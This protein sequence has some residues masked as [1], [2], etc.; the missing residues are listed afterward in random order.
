V[1]CQRFFIRKPLVG[2]LPQVFG[3]DKV[4]IQNS[5]V[6]RIGFHKPALTA[7]LW[8]AFAL[9]LTKDGKSNLHLHQPPNITAQQKAN[10][11][12]Q[13]ENLLPVLKD[14]VTHFLHAPNNVF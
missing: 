7:E 9:R 4:L 5:F 2:A 6:Q 10:A 1:H 11:A 14:Y 3:A 8:P 13:T 12:G